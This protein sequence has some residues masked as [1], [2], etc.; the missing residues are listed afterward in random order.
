MTATTL[1]NRK[2]VTSSLTGMTHARAR[3]NLQSQR[4][5]EE[6]LEGQSSVSQT[7]SLSDVSLLPL[8]FSN[9]Y[10]I[11]L[12]KDA[13]DTEYSSQDDRARSERASGRTF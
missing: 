2:L 11:A 6:I 9:L 7:S 12:M 4:L 1:E 8:H 13:V 3:K 5:E 10:A